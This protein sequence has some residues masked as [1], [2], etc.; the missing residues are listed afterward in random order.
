M[1]EPKQLVLLPPIAVKPAVDILTAD[2]VATFSG[3]EQKQPK[4][5]D[6]AKTT[7]PPPDM[8]AVQRDAK[9]SAVAPADGSSTPIP[10]PA[11]APR[12]GIPPVKNPNYLYPDMYSRFKEAGCMVIDGEPIASK[13]GG[14]KMVFVKYTNRERGVTHPL[15]VQA[16]KL[17]LP[18]GILEF[19]EKDGSVSNKVSINALCSLGREWKSNPIMVDFNNLCEEIKLECARLIFNKQLGMPYYTKLEEV[20]AAFTPMIVT[21]EKAS[22]DDPSKIVTY[23]PSIKVV[24]NTATNN[25]TLLV[26]RTTKDDK[27][28][29]NQISYHAVTKGSSMIPMIVVN[30]IYRKKR[31]MP[32][33]WSFSIHTSA[34]QAIVEASGTCSDADTASISIIV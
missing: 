32:N 6:D 17:F 33:G 22:D 18:A 19:T 31:S 24:I 29:Y 21:T 23:P 3:V 13:M 16:P 1:A 9:K 2:V 14:G 10:A 5:A 8:D 15:A 20:V 30:W 26:T 34:H 11:P 27:I 4:D 7:A 25:K 12:T 28:E